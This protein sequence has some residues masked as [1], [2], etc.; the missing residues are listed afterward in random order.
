MSQT[1]FTGEVYKL[2]DGRY[3]AR[4][5]SWDLHGDNG[6]FTSGRCLDQGSAGSLSEIKVDGFSKAGISELL[7][8]AEDPVPTTFQAGTNFLEAKKLRFHIVLKEL[9]AEFQAKPEW[10]LRSH[11]EDLITVWRTNDEVWHVEGAGGLL[12]ADWAP[13]SDEEALRLWERSQ[14]T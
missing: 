3:F 1:I 10:G 11:M 5:T 14:R 2:K 4:D 7:L 8:L 9:I 6:I 13:R 12:S